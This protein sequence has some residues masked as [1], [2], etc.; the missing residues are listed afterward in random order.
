MANDMGAPAALAASTSGFRAFGSP[1]TLPFNEL[2]KVI[3]WPL[4]L[5][6]HG[7]II[8]FFGAPPR[9]IVEAMGIPNNM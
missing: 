6:I 8:G 7:A 5:R 3:A 9:P 1:A 2:A 4:R